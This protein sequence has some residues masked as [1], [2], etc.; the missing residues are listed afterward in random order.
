MRSLVDLTAALQRAWIDVGGDQT[1]TQFPGMPLDATRL[2][3][4]FEFWVTQIDQ[5]PQR[6]GGMETLTVLLDLHC[7]SRRA[8]KR[9]VMAMADRVRQVFSQRV[10]P[11]S[12]EEASLQEGVIR[13]REAAIRDLTRE[14]GK[15]P[16]LPIQH[17]VVS[18][19]GRVEF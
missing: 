16:T 7:F 9:H 15:E 4:W 10:L 8:E 3:A 1:P 12:G 5:P 13:L 11:V 18:F 6:V 19:T 14:T 2:P 17:L